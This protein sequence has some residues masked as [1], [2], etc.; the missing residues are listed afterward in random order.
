MRKSLMRSVAVITLIA[1]GGPALATATADVLAR[2]A[3]TALSKNR[4]DSALGFA[5]AAV[6]AS[7]RN[8]GFRMVLGRIYLQS[9][10]FQ[11]AAASFADALALGRSRGDAALSLVLAQI[12]TGDI[13]AA[14]SLL[15][16]QGELIPVGDR[17]LAMALVGDTEAAIPL[18]EA[19]VRAGSSDAKTRQNLAYSYALAGRWPEAK[20]MASYDLDPSTLSARIMDWSRLTRDGQPAAQ[21]AALLGVSPAADA[22]MPVRLALNALPT[23]A[24]PAERVAEVAPPP[25]ARMI[26]QAPPAAAPLGTQAAMIPDGAEAS[27]AP[28]TPVVQPLPAPASVTIAAAK[29]IVPSKP[30]AATTAPAASRFAMLPRPTGGRFAVQIGAYDSLGVAQTSWN[31]SA[32]RI[33]MLRDYT[34]STAT[35]VSGGAVLHRLS[36]S[37]FATRSDATRVCETLRARG[38]PCFVRTTAGD[39]PLQ[40]VMRGG[41]TRLAAR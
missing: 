37:G 5:E 33:G 10:R 6:A 34:P 3:E 26:E 2:R 29:P 31:R 20:L 21:V 28:L 22:G 32:R 38:G 8:A 19:A 35:V 40:W 4:L 16:T 14:R 1:T 27:F 7:P 9:G 11:S 36:L 15:A 25:P 30:I 12:G 41:A 24:A 23:S 18:L 13:E 39:M 17:G